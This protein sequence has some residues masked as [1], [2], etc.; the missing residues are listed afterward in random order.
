M[1]TKLIFM[2]WICNNRKHFYRSIIKFRIISSCFQKVLLFLYHG[3]VCIASCTR[4]R[5]SEGSCNYLAKQL[6]TN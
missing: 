2:Y 3:L 4:A 5:E 6:I 1:F